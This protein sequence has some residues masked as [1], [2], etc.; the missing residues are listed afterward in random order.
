M[1]FNKYVA[2]ALKLSQHGR[3]SG[4]V[5]VLVKN[6]LNKYVQEISVEY[7]NVIVLRL[8]RHIFNCPDDVLYISCYVPPYGSPF[9]EQR[10]TDCFI[11]E[12]DECLSELFYELGENLGVILN[13]DFNARTARYQSNREC[14]L[15]S[16]IDNIMFHEVLEPTRISQDY[17]LNYFGK[18]LLSLCVC[19]ELEILNGNSNYDN[20][21]QFTFVSDHGHSVV[22]YFLV[23]KE[24]LEFA[25]SLHVADKIDSDHMPVEVKFKCGINS[26]N[27]ALKNV[28]VEK[29]I[30][31]E[32]KCE[33]VR[34]CLM[35]DKF[36]QSVLD[37]RELMNDNPDESLLLFTKSLLGAAECMKQTFKKGE[38]KLGGAKWYDRDCYSKKKEVRHSLKCFRKSLKREDYLVYSVTRKEYKQLI[39]KKK[40]ESKNKSINELLDSLH[41][42]KSFWGEVKK[43]RKRSGVLND[44]SKESWLQHFEK[45]FNEGT[46]I[47][48]GHTADDIESADDILDVDITQLEVKKAIQHL[49]TGKAPGADNILAEMIKFAESH[50]L[51]YLTEY[52][53]KIFSAGYFPEEWSKAIIVPLHKKG[54]R[55][56]P[57]NYRGISLL[58]VLSK[59]FTNILNGR[60]TKWCEE[61]SV[62][63]DVQA[64]FRRGRSTIDHIFTLNAAVEKHLLK[65]TKLYVAFI[66]FR[67]AYDT[68]NRAVLWSVLIKNGLHGR[69]FKMIK[70][71]YGTVQACV[72]SNCGRS[73]Y[74][75]CL[76]GLKQGCILSPMLFSLLI[77]ELANEIIEKAKHGVSLSS[78]EMELF[79]L[80]FADDLTLLSTTVIGMQTQL[81]ALSV[82][83]S[84]LGLVVS[85]EKSKIMVFRK[86]G[87]LGAK[88]KWKYEGHKLEVVNSYKYLGLSFSTRHSFTCAIEDMSLR[89]KKSAMEIVSTLRRIG[90][91]SYDVFFKLFDSQVVPTLLY[92]AEIWGSQW[93]DQIERVQLFACK[94]FMHVVNK[95]PNDLVYGD[96]GRH[97]LWI[98]AVIKQIKFWLRLLAQPDNMFS[99]KSYQ[100]LLK[101]HEKGHCNWVS[102]VNTTLCENGFE[103]VWVFGCGN[104]KQFLRELKERLVSTFCHKWRNHL[105]TSPRIETYSKFKSVFEKEKYFD[106]IWLDIYRNALAQFR[107]GVSQINKHRHRFAPNS[108]QIACPFCVDTPESEIHFLLECP[109]YSDLRDRH[110]KKL[111]PVTILPQENTFISIM[112]NQNAS[113]TF[114]VAKYLFFAQEKR[115]NNIAKAR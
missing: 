107:M 108:A 90:C 79:L 32:T 74:F 83:A 39:Q 21:G 93:F 17:E 36:Q 2:P 73:G 33:D 44:I 28:T 86:G 51:N 4:G 72:L 109:E 75:E 52:F 40:T 31:S 87:Y 92:G 61:N 71:I 47:A 113:T 25:L 100:M 68:V 18:T 29:Y 37:A 38:R 105:E 42:T 62:I 14:F 22:D 99:K 11:D 59:V 115:K 27:E 56:N 46:R 88:E 80:L 64:G 67:K 13:G 94:R 48:E 9:Y 41:D 106:C 91:N 43:H 114:Q 35:S 10:D 84:K 12:V 34:N 77:N 69:M 81:N 8:D 76:Q 26:I 98:T 110:L 97:P 58:S 45:V 55:N 19:H 49:K 30:W 89:G 1:S 53:N 24:L 57:D 5:L 85:M 66:D 6:K 103:Q 82:A 70:A 65:N 101:L 54:D 20:A 102:Q 60:L 78:A 50:I 3:R 15:E 63:N 96:L 112:K 111:M 16:E 23:D 95:T 104:E 7:A